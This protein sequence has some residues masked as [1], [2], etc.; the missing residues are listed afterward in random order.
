MNYWKMAGFYAVLL[1]V[2]LSSIYGCKRREK[3]ATQVSQEIKKEHPPGGETTGDTDMVK[4]TA[5]YPM[6]SVISIE[7]AAPKTRYVNQPYEYSMKV[8]NLT[9]VTVKN[10]EV[11]QQVP[12]KFQ[13]KSSDP[14]MP[15]GAK[16]GSFR[17][18]LG[19]LGPEETK[20][21]HATAVATEA[22]E[23]P[24]CTDVKYNL[25][26]V[27]I[28]SKIIQPEMDVAVHA[29]SEALICDAIPITIVASNKGD[30]A[31]KNVEVR[32]FLPQELKTADG[33]ADVVKN[34]GTLKP[35]ESREVSLQVKPDKTGKFTG[36]AKVVAEGGLV[37]E[38]S[39]A[40]IVIQQPVLS[41]SQ[42]GPEKRY[43]NRAANYDITV[44]NKGDGPATNTIIENPV[45]VNMSFE[46]A[47]ADGKLSNGV[48]TWNLGTLQP[49]E[50]KNISMI[51][52][53]KSLGSG[54][55]ITTARAKCA[56]PV[57]TAI[58]TKVV[59]VPGLLLEVVD[60]KDPVVIGDTTT[61][62][63]NVTNQG[64]E[65]STNIDVDCM[66]DDSMQ[67]VSSS[68]PTKGIVE[69]KTVK[70]Q[71]LA[72]LE[73]K[74]KATWQIIVKAVNQGDAR[75]ATTMMEDCLDKPVGETESTHFYK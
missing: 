44:S 73:P 6:E 53:T 28:T 23:V 70:F 47:S 54:K 16:N 72:T 71:P 60:T 30:G 57:S 66:L 14:V 9:K 49:Q 75:F 26:Q 24:L 45:P 58:T 67:Y 35:G 38:S 15:E 59:G 48:I 33:K 68:G 10:V 7:Q 74:A 12:Q 65:V 1:I 39:P 41:I 27:C 5:A 34:I 3:A 8:T 19:D 2:I 61:Y 22:G 56:E 36:A 17:W 69:G 46:G 13:I 11:I 63:I 25:P 64:S 31:L 50:T 32:E 42:K 43:I 37:F 62:T 40:T 4:V 20:T 55:S 21:I 29:P 52:L 18:A 51:L